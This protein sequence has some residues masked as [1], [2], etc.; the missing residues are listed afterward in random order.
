MFSGTFV[1]N[2]KTMRR[3]LPFLA[4]CAALSLGFAAKAPT[5]DPRLKGAYRLPQKDGWTYVHLEGSPGEIGFQ[6]GYL[7]S[8]EIK[9]TFDV[10][11]LE[12]EH[13]EKK[14]WSFFRD[15]GKTLLWPHVPD[16]YRQEMEGIAAG[17]KAQGVALDI[18]DFTALNASMEWSYYTEQYDREHAVK[19]PKTATA[20]DHCSAFVATGSYTKDGRIVIAHNNWTGYL[21]G[22]RWTIAFDIKPAAG[23]R[24]VMDG[25]PGLIHSGDDFGMN[26]AGIVITETTI[27]GFHGWDSKGIPEFVRARQAMQYSASIDDF[28]RI[29]RTG[30][31]GGYA[32][33]WLVA[34]VK[35]NEVASLELGLKNVELKRTKNGYFT[36]AN[37]PINPKLLK[38]ETD[39]K[40]NDPSLSANA[41]RVRWEQLMQKNKGKIDA[42]LA[43]EFLADHYDTVSK[44]TEPSEHTLCGHVDLSPRG[45]GDWKAKYEAAGAVQNKVADAAMAQKM[46]FQAAAGHACGLHFKVAP[47][48]A[49]HPEFAWQSPLLHDMN[50]SPWTTIQGTAIQA[51]K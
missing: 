49:G 39:F 20:P 23:H 14:P 1:Y 12:A 11:K 30:N 29:M 26:D 51:Q 18:W 34:D 48:R 32:N 28:D 6:H 36:G 13:D 10:L 24:F 7:L 44:K 22:E 3:I 41:R 19:P 42:A 31:N 40:A 21:D 50:A 38:E 33:D 46:T 4:L 16:E 27:T 17:L 15:A 47:Y 2:H 45:M 37:F 5:R 9:D 43:K 8:R 25:L 35:T